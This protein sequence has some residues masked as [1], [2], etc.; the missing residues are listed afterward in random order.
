MKTTLIE[1]YGR[2]YAAYGPQHWWPADS[3]F[4]VIVGAILTQSIAWSNVQQALANLKS[5]GVLS[6]HGLKEITEGHLATL[7]KPSGY[8]NVKA[9]KLKA[10]T[11]YLWKHYQ[12]DIKRLVNQDVVALRKG[13]LSVYGIGEETSDA[14]ILYAAD[15]PSFVIDSYS[16]RIVERLDLIKNTASYGE[17]QNYFQRTI[18][19]DTKLYNEFHALLVRH[20]QQI[21][22]RKPLCEKCCLL[23]VCPSGIIKTRN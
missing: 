4:E 15:K 3:L 8:F 11:E 7:L 16:R 6:P 20:G 17:H 19:V 13:L 10:F 21:C 1:V 9:Q 5:A 18:P 23:D 22:K 14:I 12:G 2:L